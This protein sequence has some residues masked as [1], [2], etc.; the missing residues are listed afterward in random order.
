MPGRENHCPVPR[1]I[2]ITD[3]SRPSPPITI[4]S[5]PCLGSLDTLSLPY[6]KELLAQFVLTLHAL[7]Y[8]CPIYNGTLETLNVEDRIVLLTR[9]VF[10]SVS[11]LLIV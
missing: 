8:Q 11:F 2:F 3:S 10:I 7:R 1:T 9:K 4:S 6:F 5:G